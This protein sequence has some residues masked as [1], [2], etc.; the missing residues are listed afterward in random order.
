MIT[1]SNLITELV[2]IDFAKV[3]EGFQSRNGRT[4]LVS[5]EKLC[6]QLVL[7]FLLEY[8]IDDR[9]YWFYSS[10][11]LGRLLLPK[12]LHLGG[13]RMKSGT[14]GRRQVVWVCGYVA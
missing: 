8:G 5:L 12:N 11:V 13:G 4:L 6:H 14:G 9:C 3:E 1:P 10:S 2:L 7:T